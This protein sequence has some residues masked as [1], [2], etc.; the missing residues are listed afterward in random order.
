MNEQSTLHESSGWPHSQTASE[1]MEK[2]ESPLEVL[3]N[4]NF[5]AL[6]DEADCPTNVR[7]WLHLAEDQMKVI[8]QIVDEIRA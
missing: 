5:L 6:Q 4:L 3:T 8:H 2:L 1:L 7:T